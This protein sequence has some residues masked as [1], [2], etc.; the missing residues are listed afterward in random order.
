MT[1]DEQGDDSGSE[2]GSP[3]VDSA[4]P[5]DRSGSTGSNGPD[6][7]GPVNSLRARVH[8]LSTRQKILRGGALVAVV[9]I[10]L[11]AAL[12]PTGL[13]GLAVDDTATFEAAPATPDDTTVSEAGY[14]LQTADEVTVEQQISPGGQDRTIVVNNQRR[15]Y[16]RAIEVQNR[17]FDAGVFVTLS[18]PAISVAG[19]PQNPVAGMSDRDLLQRFGNQLTEGS[20]SLAFERVGTREAVMLGESTEVGEFR[21]TVTV[22]DERQEVAVY[23]TRVRSQG[24]IVVAVGVHPTA[25][26]GDRVSLFQLMYGVDHPSE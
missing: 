9:G 4:D 12:V 6:E 17:T 13:L 15:T 5:S 16:E 1:E 3:P 24:D 26:P 21:T 11:L 25:F 8:Q 2:D 22:S 7:S 20:E 23:V 14:E 10:L 18:T 19:N